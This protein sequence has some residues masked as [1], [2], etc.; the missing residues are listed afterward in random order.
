MAIQ[1]FYFLIFWG[2]ALA[3]AAVCQMI[4][5]KLK[6]ED[7]SGIKLVLIIASYI[8]ACLFDW[9]FA[10]ELFAYTLFIYAIGRGLVHCGAR[11]EKWIFSV[12]IICSMIFLCIFK[13]GNSV[14]DV[15]G[16]L[17]GTESVTFRFVMPLG[18]SYYTFSGIWRI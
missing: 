1:S 15:C 4:E 2:V 6:K 13:Y 14:M 16:S 7:H 10:V 3:I 17:F 8:F 11:V 5:N 18:L 9:K 12:G